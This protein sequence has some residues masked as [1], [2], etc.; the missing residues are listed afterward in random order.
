MLFSD[1]DRAKLSSYCFDEDGCYF[2]E[3]SEALGASLPSNIGSFGP[4]MIFS[5]T[6]LYILAGDG[7]CCFP[8]T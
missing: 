5:L 6:L 4:L 8:T 2:L 1:L 3:G 7:F